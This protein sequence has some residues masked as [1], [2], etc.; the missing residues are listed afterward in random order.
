MAFFF[1]LTYRFLLALYDSFWAQGPIVQA[2]SNSLCNWGWLRPSCPPPKC[3]GYIQA[4][5]Y[6]FYIVLVMGPRALCL[7]CKHALIWDATPAC[8]FSVRGGQPLNCKDFKLWSHSETIESYLRHH[9]SL[10]LWINCLISRCLRFLIFWAP[11]CWVSVW[12]DLNVFKGLQRG[13]LET[14]TG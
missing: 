11:T 1:F 3:W 7:L 12:V 5:P 10:W 8:G 6:L 2:T 13:L 4:S 9:R 14:R